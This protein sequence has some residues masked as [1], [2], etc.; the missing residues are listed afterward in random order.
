MER[1]GMAPGQRE[2]HE[3]KERHQGEKSP[4]KDCDYQFHFGKE[5]MV[6]PMLHIYAVNTCL[7]CHS[8]FLNNLPSFSP[9]LI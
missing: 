1:Q 4:K 3:F 7:F 6:S 9:N 2:Q 8:D 5:K